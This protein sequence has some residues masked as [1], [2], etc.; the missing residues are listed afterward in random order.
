M[1]S[2]ILIDVC[3]PLRHETLDLLLIKITLYNSTDILN[4]LKRNYMEISCNFPPVTMICNEPA[5]EGMERSQTHNSNRVK[6]T[7]TLTNSN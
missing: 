4:I 6:T 5:D 2:Q 7:F 3:L 1:H